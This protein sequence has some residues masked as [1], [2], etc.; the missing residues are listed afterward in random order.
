MVLFITN[1]FLIIRL[2][3]F[4]DDTALPFPVKQLYMHSIS[5]II[6]YFQP[7]LL[8]LVVSVNIPGAGAPLLSINADSSSLQ[9]AN[10]AAHQTNKHI[11]FT[12]IKCG[13]SA[14]WGTKEAENVFLTQCWESGYRCAGVSGH[15]A[16]VRFQFLFA[17]RHCLTFPCPPTREELVECVKLSCVCHCKTIMFLC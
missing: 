13:F 1:L 12:V 6:K 14:G 9:E 17:I 16:C 7:T 15:V 10:R 4:K 3:L 2:L 11:L 5:Q 8:R